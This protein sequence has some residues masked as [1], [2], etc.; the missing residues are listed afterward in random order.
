[1]LIYFRVDASLL[2]GT[3]HVMRCLSLAEQ[4][5]EEGNEVGFICRELQGNLINYIKSKGYVVHILLNLTETQSLQS[6]YRSSY[7]EWLGVPWLTDAE[8]TIAQLKQQK[9][10]IDWLIIDHYALDGDYEKTIQPFVRKILVI[11]DLAN[12]KHACSIL[13]DHNYFDPLT[14]RYEDLVD[15]QCQLIL[16]PNY[17]LLRKEFQIK[18]P[19][20]RVRDGRIRNVLVSFGGVD[21]TGETMKTLQ[22]IWPFAQQGLNVNVLLGKM[23]PHSK[24]IMEFCRTMPRC[25]AYGHVE[26]MRALMEKADLAIGAGGTSTWE[27]CSLGLPSLVITTAENQEGITDHISRTGAIGYLGRSN[28]VT[29]WMI[30]ERVKQMMTHP[31]QCREM[32]VHAAQLVDGLGV[33]RISKELSK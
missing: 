33:Q 13:L 4:L 26:N 1:M 21:L 27:R 12:R 9:K 17:A 24:E 20:A 23:N 15:S 16:G 6:A 29:S 14:S 25:S 31:E 3:G 8:Q 2:I 30:H 18:Q 19:A 7:E 22:A 28:E 5:R 10:Q 11:D 32:S